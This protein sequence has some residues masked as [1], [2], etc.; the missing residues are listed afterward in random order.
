MKE[1]DTWFSPGQIHFTRR[2]SLWLVQNLG[3]LREGQWPHEASSYIDI[4]GTK[5][6]SGRAPFA[7]PIEYAAEIS[8]RLEKC[9][10]GHI[11]DG[12]ILLAIECW[13]ESPDSLAKYF[14][15]SKRLIWK[16]RNR[17]LSY[18]SSGT[19]RKWVDTRKRKGETYQE[20][21]DSAKR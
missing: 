19:W 11:P 16:G 15:V 14:R 8:T 5:G 21:K 9:T 2:T 13:G 7:T 6:I 20:F 3:T 18:V 1:K 12:L 4:P 17:A 10:M